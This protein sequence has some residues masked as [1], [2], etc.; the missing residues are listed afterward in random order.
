MCVVVLISTWPQ[1]SVK[2]EHTCAEVISGGGNTDKRVI[3]AAGARDKESEAE[4]GNARVWREDGRG[5]GAAVNP[6]VEVEARC[7]RLC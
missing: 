3:I 7:G 6:A 2:I 4:D 1:P 5:G